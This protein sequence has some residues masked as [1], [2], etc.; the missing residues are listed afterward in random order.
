VS[1]EYRIGDWPPDRTE[2]MLVDSRRHEIH[3]WTV[4]TR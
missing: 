2:T 3:F 4:P 1:H